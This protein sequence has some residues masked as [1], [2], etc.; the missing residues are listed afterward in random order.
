MLLSTDSDEDCTHTCI[1]NHAQKYYETNWAFDVSRFKNGQNTRKH[2]LFNSFPKENIIVTVANHPESGVSTRT[3]VIPRSE[4]P[5]TTVSRDSDARSLSSS[6][7]DRLTDLLCLAPPPPPPRDILI[8]PR[9]LHWI[10]LI[11]CL[12]LPEIALAHLNKVFLTAWNKHL[13]CTVS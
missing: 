5:H 3:S 12:L 11:N 6:A 7:G 9:T 4:C 8:S 1:H 10:W 13:H 2:H